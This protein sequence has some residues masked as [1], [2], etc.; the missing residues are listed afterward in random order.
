VLD[1][2]GE[3]GVVVFGAV[4][5]VVAFGLVFGLV[6][7]G[8][9]WLGV[10]LGVCPF[11]FPSGLLVPG[12]VVLGFVVPGLPVF[13][14]VVPGVVVPGAVPVGG[15]TEPVGG[16]VVDPGVRAWPLWPA[17]PGAA[18]PGAEPADPAPPGAACA[19][20]QVAHSKTTE[21]KVK[22]L[23]DILEGL[24]EDAR[25]SVCNADSSIGVVSAR[26]EGETIQRMP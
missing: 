25:R 21:S 14:F 16:G 26:N 17:A 18:P 7:L 1:G 20:I 5:G 22:F 4:L 8:F 9:V 15:F 3:F 13:G 19:T 10:S 12:V 11:M 6:P 24:Q 23:I 2:G